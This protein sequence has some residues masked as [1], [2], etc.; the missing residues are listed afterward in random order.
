M[1]SWQDDQ[2]Q[3]LFAAT[4][5][6]QLFD[7]LVKLVRK[8]GFDLCSYGIR[9]PFPV[10]KPRIMVFDNYPNSWHQQYRAQG[11][12]E[13]DPTVRH[14]LRSLMPLVWTDDVF[15][16]APEFWEDARGQG[17]RYGWAQPCRDPS[18]VAGMLTVARSNE[19]LSDPELKLKVPRLL[20][21]TQVAHVAMSR[22]VVHRILPESELRF[23]SREIAVMRWTA[24]GKTSGDI[25]D[26]L[27]ITERTVNF[28]IGNVITKLNAANKTAAAIRMAVMG[29]LN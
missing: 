20:W 4:G 3:S 6:Q 28:H 26:I 2:L 27:H 19:P 16:E 18:G 1:K 15:A 10:S 29:L 14:G 8:E 9:P 13:I 21:M 17:L 5:E 25:A 23:S 12:V 11:Y 7:A 24:E 22:L